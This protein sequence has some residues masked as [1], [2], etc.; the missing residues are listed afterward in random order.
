LACLPFEKMLA[1]VVTLDT[2]H[3]LGSAPLEQTVM[4]TS[5]CFFS[6]VDRQASSADLGAWLL[7]G[8]SV[9]FGWAGLAKGKSADKALAEVT[10]LMLE[11]GLR[12]RDAFERVETKKAS[13]GTLL[14]LRADENDDTRARH[15]VF[16]ADED[17]RAI[18]PEG[19]GLLV[20]E[21]EGDRGW[22]A[23][24]PVLFSGVLPDEVGAFETTAAVLTEQG[25]ARFEPDTFTPSSPGFKRGGGEF[26]YIVPVEVVFGEQAP[27]HGERVDLRVRTE[28]PEGGV[29]GI[30]GLGAGI[31]AMLGAGESEGYASFVLARPGC[32]LATL[33]FSGGGGVGWHNANN[34]RTVTIPGA[35][36]FTISMARAERLGAG[37]PDERVEESAPAFSITVQGALPARGDSRT[38]ASE[39]VTF[40]GTV[41]DG[42]GSSAY[43]ASGR[44]G[45]GSVTLTL[46]HQDDG[47]LRGRLGGVALY[48]GGEEFLAARVD[49]EFVSAPADAPG[50]TYQCF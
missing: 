48:P 46:T 34:V 19:V 24:T 45:D 3:A 28:L 27:K 49:V 12:A 37:T 10:K 41:V 30:G 50:D 44:D 16:F 4:Y 35:D 40:T 21:Y 36:V 17:G 33:G 7:S 18:E 25:G 29:S 26:D 9:A 13:N 6:S 8:D 47:S 5:S 32:A 31:G 43:A 11:D 15:V 42:V 22:V 2:L 23:P 20:A 38:Y 39:L 1:I 14:E